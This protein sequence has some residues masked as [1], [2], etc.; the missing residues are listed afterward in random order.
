[1]KI[2]LKRKASHV[3]E[4]LFLKNNWGQIVL[5]EKKCCLCAQR[6]L[7][8]TKIKKNIFGVV[9]DF[10]K[11]IICVDENI[12]G[13]KTPRLDE[14]ILKYI[15]KNQCGQKIFEQKPSCMKIFLNSKINF[16]V[17]V[18]QDIFGEKKSGRR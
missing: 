7:K 1:M 15:L 4:Y 2:Y 3:D 17:G 16:S 14:D 13:E 18:D 10:F 12:F 8:K 5:G 6:F 11:N 9:E